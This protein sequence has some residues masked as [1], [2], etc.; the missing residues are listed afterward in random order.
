[1]PAA[2]SGRELCKHA[3]LAI[4]ITIASFSVHA[5]FD[6]TPS[7]SQPNNPI[8]EAT[9]NAVSEYGA[10]KILQGP[11]RALVRRPI[12]EGDAELGV[13][14]TDDVKSWPRLYRTRQ[15]ARHW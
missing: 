15:S 14:Q 12:P 6:N 13:L 9:A 4:A 11:L 8:D 10:S 1:M 3:T 5:Q 7:P 2:T